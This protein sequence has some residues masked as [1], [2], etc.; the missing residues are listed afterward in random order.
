MIDRGVVVLAGGVGAARLL[1]GVIRA[2]DPARVTAVVNT[3]DDTVLHGL[4]ISPDL[5]TV[6]YTLAEAINT[7]TGWGLAGETWQAMDALKRY[8]G[9]TWFG[10]GDRD[11]ATHMYRTQRLNEGATL[12][13]VT[14]EI[15]AAWELPLT[16]LPVTNDQVAT[17]VTVTDPPEA[18]GGST[19]GDCGPLEIG[20]QEY[21]VQRQ[22][23]VPVHSVRFDGAE[24]ASVSPEV[25]AALATSDITVIA[26]SNPIVSI[27]PLL[28]VDGVRDHLTANR[29]K[30]VAVSPIIGGKAL[31]GPA[32][33]MMTELGHEATAVGVAR[34]Y[35]D[36]ASVLVID[37]ADA[38]SAE[39]VRSLGLTPVVTNTIMADVDIAT[40]LAQTVLTAV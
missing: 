30:V 20:F 1:R 37:T 29:D 12:T 27:G 33:R 19:G 14:A 40:E 25:R 4:H 34:M 35:A 17:K 2:V 8:D 9:I 32:D 24:S 31:K 15:V 38:D 18:N 7:E 23:S 10:L 5:D 21:F 28:A 22:H 39:E 11:L 26:P 6:T 13:E 3:G 36:I 16:L